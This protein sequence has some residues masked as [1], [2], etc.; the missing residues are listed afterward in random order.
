MATD[1]LAEVAP[2]QQAPPGGEPGDIFLAVGLHSS[3]PSLPRPTLNLSLL[4]DVS[5]SM[6]APFRS[7]YYGGCGRP[8]DVAATPGGL[9]IR[10]GRFLGPGSDGMQPCRLLMQPTR[11]RVPACL[12]R[13]FCALVHFS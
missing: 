4:L 10:P 12:S 9:P 11:Q 5:G 8:A 2:A 1:P 3:L 7:F 6:A 13:G